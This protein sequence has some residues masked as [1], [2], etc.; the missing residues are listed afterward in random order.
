MFNNAITSIKKMIKV[1]YIFENLLKIITIFEKIRE[2][3][4]NVELKIFKIYIYT[5]NKL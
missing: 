5:L 1:Q 4:R 3:V 2:C